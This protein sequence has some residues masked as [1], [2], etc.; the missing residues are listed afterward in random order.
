MPMK[1]LGSTLLAFPRWWVEVVLKF[2]EELEQVAKDSNCCRL[3]VFARAD[4]TLVLVKSGSTLLALQLAA[5]RAAE[6]L[7]A[8]L[9]FRGRL[10]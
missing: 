6:L 7:V 10:L 4:K 2:L 3:E 8:A 5:P 1:Y 9:L